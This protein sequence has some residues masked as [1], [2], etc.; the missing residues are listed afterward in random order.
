MLLLNNCKKIYSNGNVGI[1]NVN[2]SLPSKGIIGIYGKSGSGKSTLINCIGGLDE[3][4]EGE[5]YLDNTLVK[6]LFDYSTYIFQEYKLIEELSVMDNLL[7]SISHINNQR[8]DELLT[9]FGIIQLKNEKVNNISGGQRQR[10]EVVRAIIQNSSIILCD[11][12]IANVDDETGQ[13]I[14]KLLKELS[15]EKL[16]LIVSHNVQLL[17]KYADELIEIDAGEIIANS[18][19]GKNIESSNLKKLEPNKLSN[20]YALFISM[21]NIKKNKL[22]VFMTFIFMFLSFTI[23]SIGL[24]IV[25]SN[26]PKILYTAYDSEG[27][28]LVSFRKLDNKTNDSSW[29]SLPNE[30]IDNIDSDIIIYENACF[31]TFFN[32][33]QLYFNNV[34]V[35]NQNLSKQYNLNDSQIIVSADF[36]EVLS[37]TKEQ[38]LGSYIEYNNNKYE[39]IDII[40]TMG[41]EKTL[42]ISNQTFN[43]IKAN[44]H[45]NRT[46]EIYY[47]ESDKMRFSIYNSFVDEETELVYGGLPSEP[48]E[49]VISKQLIQMLNL[50]EDNL[51]GT[52]I[53]L[54]YSTKS[55]YDENENKESLDYKIV[56]VSNDR[57]VLYEEIFNDFMAKFGTE[58]LP[59]K[60]TSIGYL[61]YDLDTF[62]NAYDLNLCPVDEMGSKIYSIYNM[63]LDIT[64]ILWVMV[65]IFLIIS[66]FT[67]FNSTNSSILQNKKIIGVFMSFKVKIKSLIKI[68]LFENALSCFI[69]MILSIVIYQPVLSLIN[70]MIKEEWIINNSFIKANY[71]IYVLLFIFMLA[72]LSIGLI[73]PMK[74]L[75]SKRPID[76]LYDRI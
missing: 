71:M 63:L 4:T 56:G 46:V 32:K 20:K 45:D 51:L 19:N 48:N 7:L 43:N 5:I 28:G 30:I 3:F 13:I 64:P 18:C 76:I 31:K 66:I 35:M 29:Y 52:N 27:I 42:I 57:L 74:K 72:I 50:N 73:I 58:R 21:N 67:I 39:I 70:L 41:Y 10:V 36:L 24:S 68:Y 65:A 1:K 15:H 11:E 53:T 22:K 16:I 62:Y 12:P 17:K 44:I 40:D 38:L 6:N 47:N 59:S 25:W 69:A 33:K 23:L 75:L 54:N 26:L 34:W 49:M 60:L 9:M 8:I 55:I 2:I 14:L 61:D 37:K